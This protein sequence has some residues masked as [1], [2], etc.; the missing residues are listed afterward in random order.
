MQPDDQ[1]IREE[2]MEDLWNLW[3]TELH[4]GISGLTLKVSRVI[5]SAESEFQRIEVIE[6][7]EFGKALVLYGSLMVAEG[8][9]GA[10]NEMIAHV[11]L[12]VHPNPGEVLVIGGGDGG[13]V[14]NVLMHPEVNRCTICEIDRT[15]IEIAQKHFPKL[16]AGLSDPRCRMIFEDGK[17]FIAD[18][19]GK[20][21]IVILDLSDPIGPA[22]DLFQ[23]S[24]H[25]SVYDC[26]RDDGIMVAQSE[27]P[28]FNPKTV[29]AM[30]SNLKS[31]FP[32]VRMYT[33]I[34]PIYPSSYWSFAFCSKKYDPLNDFDAERYDRTDLSACSY[35][36]RDVHFGSFALPTYVKK[37]I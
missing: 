5:E 21:D 20:F 37:L 33:C 17:K 14:T 6:T 10:Y 27:S 32:I 28:L 13:C 22:A 15:V 29:G 7:D 2:S 24:F 4:Q 16:T 36:N 18:T 30:Y 19:A 26:L 9:T 3:F 31:I 35:Y 34:M 23:K 25:Q 8:D 1:Y 11:P 12:L